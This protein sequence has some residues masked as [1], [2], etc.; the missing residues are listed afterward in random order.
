VDGVVKIWNLKKQACV[1]TEQMH[2]EKVWGLDVAH[3]RYL[4][5]GGGDSTLKLWRDTTAEQ[6]LEEKEK[7][8][9]RVQDEH[10]LSTLIRQEDF[11]EAALM[12]FR[13]NKLRD[14]YLVVSKILANKTAKVDP[15]DS[16]L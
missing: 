11:I 12:A 6:E 13:L 7:N 4:L 5:T 14:F 1:A 3:D 8:L 10:K 15:V 2:E 9:Q 16:V